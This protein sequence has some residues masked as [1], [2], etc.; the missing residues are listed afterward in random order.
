MALLLALLAAGCA[1]PS[2]ACAPT[3]DVCFVTDD[4]WVLQAARSGNETGPWA[5]LVHGLNEDHHSYDALARDL[6][7]AGWRALALDSRG[8]GAS[9]HRT[10]GTTHALAS[11]G[12]ADFL[13]MERDLDASAAFL[14][15]EPSL[16][17]GASV[18]ANEAI[19]H[20]APHADTAVVLLSPGLDYRGLTTRDADA[21]HEGRAYFT[22]SAEDQYA[23]ESARE[24]DAAHA[25]PHALRVWSGKGH[26]TNLLDNETR[27]AVVDWL[28]AG[29][30][31]PAGHIGI[32]SR[33][34]GGP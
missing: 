27:R 5:L 24:L 3:L 11:F 26:G 16:I 8:H 22:A 10:D 34:A 15:S 7:A 25:G 33:G 14:G 32:R 19:R 4:G 9:T 2:P 30:R 6:V 12:P 13:A 17:V 31:A 1:A 18:G 29:T 23:A 20:A 28:Q 21:A